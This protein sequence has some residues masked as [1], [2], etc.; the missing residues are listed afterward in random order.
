VRG[1]VSSARFLV[2]TDAAAELENVVISATVGS[3]T[4]AQSFTLLP[5][6]PDRFSAPHEVF[7]RAGSIARFQVGAT[8]AG[9][10]SVAVSASQLPGAATFDTSTNTFEWQPGTGD[11]GS[12]E[13]IFT[14]TLATGESLRKIVRINV[15]TGAPV[16]TA[17]SNGA[18]K[19]APAACSPGAVAMLEGHFLSSSDQAVSDPSASSTILGGVRVLVNSQYAR[20]LSAS[21]ERVSFLC[22]SVPVS[23]LRISA[24]NEMGVSGP[25]DVAMQDSAPG[26]F[27]IEGPD[28][29]QAVATLAASGEL[30]AVANHRVAGTPALPG[31]TLAVH[32]TGIDCSS[33]SQPMLQIGPEYAKILSVQPSAN[34]GVC[35]IQAAVPAG[36]SGDSVPLVL[37]AVRADGTAVRSNTAF[38][39]VDLRN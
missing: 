8:D 12:H 22:P 6:A 34:A 25:I 2:S 15:G 16:L 14:T 24:E 28:R 3:E 17:L 38:I 33:T 20:V 21:T 7:V 36:I 4:V 29:R 18:S 5:S 23:T 13:A 9:N 10:V 30:A 39:A 32:V 19:D 35:V 26:I 31:D 1:D 11:L 27:T 37:Q